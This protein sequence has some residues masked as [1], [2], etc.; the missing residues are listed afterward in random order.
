MQYIEVIISGLSGEPAE[1]LTAGMC[2]LGFES[3][4]E[5]TYGEFCAYIPLEAF[6]IMPVSNYL[7]KQ[8][9]AL[10]FRYSV[11][12]VADR[13]WNEV[14]ESS[15]QPVRI[16]GCYIRAPFHPPDREASV[17]L[18][19]EPKMSFGTAHHETTRMMIEMLLQ[20]DLS[21]ATVLDMGT[22]TGI[23][24]ILAVKSGASKVAAVDIDDW[25]CLN[26]EENIQRN[27]VHG[28]KVIKGTSA[29]T[30]DGPYQ[31]ILANINRNVLLADLPV[32]F[33]LL[34]EGGCLM[35]SGFYLDDMDI[36]QKAAI[37]LGFEKT[38]HRVLN[39]WAAVSY[40]KC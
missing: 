19:I 25:S 20:T 2:E 39:N 18:L 7:E 13:N 38:G 10:G 36:I 17:E 11:S 16:G 12:K 21:G 1:I 15:Y 30:P 4:S 27:E 32:Y 33:N 22:G 40:K 6:D 23:L 28:I 37:D 5:E 8:S 3:F 9:A 31:Y 35:M 29:E 14:W 26:A 34:S 24:A